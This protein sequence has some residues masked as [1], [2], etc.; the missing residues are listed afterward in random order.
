MVVRSL[1]LWAGETLEVH[2]VVGQ[3]PGIG[4]DAIP[5]EARDDRQLAVALGVLRIAAAVEPH[6]RAHDPVLQI[7]T[8]EFS[9]RRVAPEY[10]PIPGGR[11]ADVLDDVLVLIRP[12][13]VEV[14]VGFGPA[15]HR[16]GRRAPLPV[17]VV[18]VLDAQA[19]EEGMK[20]V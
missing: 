13:R 12:E 11:E 15:Q 20:M 18:P 17:A 4:R 3:P 16:P 10:E 7:E 1:P 5:D 6:R 2:S 8:E 19:P 14:V 9:A